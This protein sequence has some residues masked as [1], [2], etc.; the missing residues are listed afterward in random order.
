M[1]D[2]KKY[3]MLILSRLV[4]GV[5]IHNNHYVKFGYITTIT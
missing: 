2:K 3:N 5:S 1:V 4:Y